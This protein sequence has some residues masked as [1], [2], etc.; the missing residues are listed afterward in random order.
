MPKSLMARPWLGQLVAACGYGLIYSLFHDLLLSQ[1]SLSFGLRLAVLAVTPYKY[2]LAL[3]VG[4][5]ASSAY[6]AVT[7]AETF[8]VMWSILRAIPMIG[9]VMPVVYVCRE[10]LRLISAKRVVNVPA[11]VLGALGVSIITVPFQVGLL[12]LAHL[13]ANYPL[14]RT[15]IFPYFLMN[16][17]GALTVA[18]LALCLRE[19]MPRGMV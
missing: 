9:L 6:I 3:A 19:T 8:G 11:L 4:E 17:S 12:S 10:R 1:Y 18:P 7:C 2:W 15:W 14:P 16:Y 5:T 13:P